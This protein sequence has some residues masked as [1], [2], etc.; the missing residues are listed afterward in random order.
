MF[1]H[2]L[3]AAASAQPATAS[4]DAD[5]GS[6]SEEPSLLSDADDDGCSDEGPWI[7]LDEVDFDQIEERLDVAI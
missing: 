1:P 7:Q 3:S 5:Q 6:S 4:V 2:Q